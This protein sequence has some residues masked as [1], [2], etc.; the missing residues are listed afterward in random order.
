MMK[1]KIIKKPIK[2]ALTKDF[3][4]VLLAMIVKN[5]E[6]VYNLCLFY[7]LKFLTNIQKLN[8][9]ILDSMRQNKFHCFIGKAFV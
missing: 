2:T 6:L 1:V 3:V 7:M 5:K 9:F 8:S 4:C